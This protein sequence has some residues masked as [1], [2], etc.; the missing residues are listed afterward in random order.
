MATDVAARGLDIA[1]LPV[2]INF[3]VPFNA[4]DYVH[5]IG[6]TGRAGA[7]G[8][9]LMLVTAGADD[10]N[11]AA[12]EHLIKEKFNRIRLD[13][14]PHRRAPAR[15]PRKTYTPP[16]V[17]PVSADPFFNQPYEPSAEALS[18]PQPAPK[19]LGSTKSAATPA[20]RKA[21]VAALLG[22]L[23]RK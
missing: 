17:T 23:I 18:R 8:V 16:P 14:M 21:P 22:G 5:R 3:D 11:V 2:V 15:G 20:K 7:K 12:I 10:K 6:R 9:A 19:S 4:E 1:E 13:V